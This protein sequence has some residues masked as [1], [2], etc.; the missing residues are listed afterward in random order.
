VRRGPKGQVGGSVQQPVPG[1]D[2]VAGGQDV[3]EVGA[4]VPVNP[5][6]TP[7]A[8]LEAGGDGQVGVGADPD[9]HQD[10]VGGGHEVGLAGHH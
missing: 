4:H 2:A 7:H 3:G 10:Q 1:L 5:Q 9:H 6:G 8:G